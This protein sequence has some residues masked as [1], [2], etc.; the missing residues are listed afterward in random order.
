[1]GCD[2]RQQCRTSYGLVFQ[3]THPGWGATWCRL[4]RIITYKEFQSTHPGWGATT[5]CRIVQITDSDFNPRTPGGV[6]LYRAI[7]A[8]EKR[9]IS[10]HAP[11]VGCDLLFPININP[12]E[13]ISIHAPRVGCDVRS[14]KRAC[15]FLTFQSTH[16]GWGATFVYFIRRSNNR[17]QSTHPGWGATFF[18]I[19][20]H[21]LRTISIHAPRVGCDAGE[22]R[23]RMTNSYFNPRTPGGVRR[24]FGFPV[25]VC[26]DISIHA[27]RVGCD[28]AVRKGALGRPISIHAPRVGCD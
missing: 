16:P 14:S 22:R 10:I 5:F 19:L 1:M 18:A 4:Y 23:T 20:R 9:E 15:V 8:Q 26:R 25:M 7:D 2:C 6:R 17:F 12:M 13:V 24:E 28:P 27:P 11:R 3:S 21:R